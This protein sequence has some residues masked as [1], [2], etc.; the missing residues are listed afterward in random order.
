M[1]L[2]VQ[3]TT[4]SMRHDLRDQFVCA[5]FSLRHVKRVAVGTYVPSPEFQ[6]S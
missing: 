6:Y 5:F 4:K 2:I 3:G 1:T